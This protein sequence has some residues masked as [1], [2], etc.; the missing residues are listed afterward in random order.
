[1]Y[2]AYCKST[3]VE[4]TDNSTESYSL[5]AFYISFYIKSWKNGDRQLLLSSSVWGAWATASFSKTEQHWFEMRGLSLIK[6]INRG[7]N[8]YA[9]CWSK[10]ISGWYSLRRLNTQ[11]ITSLTFGLWSLNKTYNE[12]RAYPITSRN[13]YFSGPFV[14]DP[15]A[16]SPA[17][18][19]FQSSTAWI[20]A[21]TDLITRS[22]M[23]FWMRSAMAW[24][25]LPAARQGPYS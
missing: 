18:L 6:S 10:N 17:N 9:T 24:R 21:A 20:F 13:F 14:I 22:I 2:D 16:M 19:F 8:Y 4:L 15:R 25:Q 7:K 11:Q 23:S 1:M 5:F 3:P 12:L